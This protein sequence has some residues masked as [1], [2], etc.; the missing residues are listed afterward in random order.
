MSQELTFEVL[1]HEG[2]RVHSVAADDNVAYVGL[3]PRVVMLDVT[4][5]NNVQPMARS[6]V[7]PGLVDVVLIGEDLLYAGAGEHLLALQ[8][9]DGQIDVLAE[10]QLPGTISHLML[11]DDMLYAAGSIPVA[12][13]EQSSGF[14]SAVAHTGDGDLTLVD[15]T[16]LPAA[17]TGMARAGDLLYVALSPLGPGP[18]ELFVFDLTRGTFLDKP[19]TVRLPFE[20][21]V[22]SLHIV[23]ETLLAGGHMNLYA[24]DTGAPSDSESVSLE[25]LWQVEAS[26]DLFLPM[27]EGMAVVGDTIYVVG[28]VPAGT[29]IPQRL[30]VPAPEPLTPNPNPPTSPLVSLSNNRFFVAEGNSL[31]I[32]DV[33]QPGALT[34]IGGYGPFPTLMSTLSIHEP[35]PGEEILYLYSAGS[36]DSN[37]EELFTFRLP[38]LQPLGKL[39]IEAAEE[40]QM[41]QGALFDLLLQENEAYAVARDGIRQVDISDPSAPRVVARYPF[42]EGALSPRGLVAAGDTLYLG[43][44]RPPQVAAISFDTEEGRQTGELA[45]SLQGENL[46]AMAAAGDT[47]YVATVDYPEQGRLYTIDA[48]TDQPELLATLSLPG[49][50]IWVEPTTDGTLLAVAV[51]EQ[52]ILVDVSEPGRPQAVGA[53]TLPF[54]TELFRITKALAFHE[55]LLFVTAGSVLLAIDVFDPAAPRALGAFQLPSHKYNRGEHLAVAGNIVVVGDPDMGVLVLR[56]SQ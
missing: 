3:G 23:G 20:D 27:V 26:P 55:D 33:S 4:E 28:N 53:V 49:E 21:V 24:L 54:S 15:A 14:L 31:E 12:P 48:S 35:M 43:L 2:G 7:L 13:E 32:Y 25:L 1:S 16:I 36:N 41:S 8:V 42:T 56:M 30:A 9:D 19:A 5:P 47:V 39:S 34:H 40:P 17:V 29:Y 51:G 10:I 6:R 38:N 11:L 22:H 18:H 46:T 50:P 44:Q 37:P 52:L 45:R